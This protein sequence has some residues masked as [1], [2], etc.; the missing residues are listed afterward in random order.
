MTLLRATS[1]ELTKQF[2]T[3][4]WWILALVL[5]LYVGMIATGLAFAIA[6]SATGALPGTTTTGEGPASGSLIYSLANSIGYVFPLLIGTLLVTGEFRHKTLT[7][8]FLAIPRRGAVLGGKL[9]AGA[10]LGL[11]YGVI[12]VVVTAAPGAAV[13]AGFG[14]ETGLGTGDTWA[15]LGRILIAFVLWV[16]VG[17]GTGL[18]V[19]NQVAAIVIVLAFTQFVEPLLRVGAAFVESLS[20]IGRFLPGAA[21]DALVGASALNMGSGTADTLAWWG[22]GLVLL[23]YAVVL[24]LIGYVT[25]WRRDVA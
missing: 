4:I 12:A 9:L 8:T 19:R 11:L 22:G 18:V 13:F 24:L 15:M 3:A 21:G 20:G 23:G 1:S 17:I 16:L 7:P 5:A 10:V 14:L 2:T 6:A 25:S